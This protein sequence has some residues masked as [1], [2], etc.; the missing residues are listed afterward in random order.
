MTEPGEE[1]PEQTWRDMP[2][3]FLAG[4]IV[5]VAVLAGLIFL[6]QMSQPKGPE[7]A[8]K[9]PFGPAEQDY[10]QHVQFANIQM[11]RAKNMLNQEFTY[12]GGTMWNEGTKTI[13]AMDVV[14]EFK[15]PFNQVVLRDTERLVTLST[16][17]LGPSQ[18]RDFQ[19]TLEHI[20]DEW[21]QQ[22]L[23]FRITGLLLKSQ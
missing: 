11:A 20:P 14:I 22:Y 19:V 18:T 7:A 6:I 1:R 4:A 12:V 15:D 10:A 16:G 23:T 9:L 3:K 5:V 13:R 17:P 21:N 8:K 2:A